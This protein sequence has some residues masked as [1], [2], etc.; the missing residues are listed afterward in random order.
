MEQWLDNTARVL[1]A[2]KE[3]NE[4]LKQHPDVFFA[5]GGKSGQYDFTVGGI[6]KD[7]AEAIEKL[8]YIVLSE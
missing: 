8:L 6:D 4:A 2:L 1:E 3:A 7:A 5:T